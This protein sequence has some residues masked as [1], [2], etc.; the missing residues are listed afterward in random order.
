V[1]RS[2]IASKSIDLQSDNG[3]VLWSLV[4]GEQLEFQINLEFLPDITNF[5]IEAVVI[6]GFNDGAGTIPTTVKAPSPVVTNLGIVVPT[7]LG[8][9][10]IGMT[11][12]YNELTTYYGITYKWISVTPSTSADVPGVSTN[13]QVYTNNKLNIKFPKT[14]SSTYSVQPAPEAPVY[15]FFELSIS[16]GSNATFPRIWKPVR[17]IIEFLFSPTE[18]N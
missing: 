14:L 3:S 18:L 12:T 8:E 13:W 6:E 2:R 7:H 10:Y 5:D 16:E 1:A 17:G 9:W 4:Q 15:A 11:A